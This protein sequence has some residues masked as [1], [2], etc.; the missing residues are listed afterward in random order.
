MGLSNV[1]Y[2]EIISPHFSEY[3][4]FTFEEISRQFLIRL[5]KKNKLGSLYHGFG[6]WWGTDPIT[7]KTGRNRFG[8]FEKQVCN[9]CRM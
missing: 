5:N 6:R 8:G 2:D 4:G 3:F 7:K 9:I 1:A